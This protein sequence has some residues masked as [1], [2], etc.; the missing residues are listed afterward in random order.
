MLKS[1]AF[2]MIELVFVIVIIGILSAVAAPRIVASRE[3]A[4]FAVLTSSFKQAVEEIQQYVAINGNVPHFE[5]TNE[6][7][8][9]KPEDNFML[10][11]YPTPESQLGGG[12]NLLI[13]L[14]GND[15]VCIGLSYTRGQAFDPYHPEK[16]TG[17][18]FSV[19]PEQDEMQATVIYGGRFK[20]NVR[21]SDPVR[22]DHHYDQFDETPLCK[23]FRKW[24]FEQYGSPN[25]VILRYDQS[26]FE[27]EHY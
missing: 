1:R 4:R 6:P 10:K 2:T 25:I 21:T 15:Y 27:Q 9:G 24:A 23:K 13:G 16:G 5:I 20:G 19:M 18:Y 22:N 17:D 14:K 11:I 26:L 8:W 3:D 7:V 12:Y